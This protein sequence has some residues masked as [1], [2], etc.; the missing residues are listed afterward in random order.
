[1]NALTVD[2]A[3]FRLWTGPA[4]ERPLELPVGAGL[5]ARVW[6]PRQPR[7]AV[8]IASP[9]TSA[10]HCWRERFIANTLSRAGFITV[11]A[12]LL[13]EGERAEVPLLAGRLAG[14]TRWVRAQADSS[15]LPLGFVGIG[16]ASAA[17]F[18]V[19]ALEEREV[20]ALVSRAGHPQLAGAALVIV[21]APSLFLV[22]GRDTG[23]LAANEAACGLPPRR[24][25]SEANRGPSSARRQLE[26]IPSVG[27]ITEGEALARIAVSSASW[28]SR[29]ST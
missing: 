4:A 23:E 1:V 26:I 20:L 6:S 3:A 10:R 13:N 25:G 19:A 14:V 8:I 24:S 27:A 18:I 28:F 15:E 9:G 17:S 5:G 11:L 12:D 7:G 22:E 16:P 21:R 29:W 2:R